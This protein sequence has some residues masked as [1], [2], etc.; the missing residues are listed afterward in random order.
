MG[1]NEPS[2]AQGA[3]RL[4]LPQWCSCFEPIKTQAPPELTAR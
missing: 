1:I 4:A 2:D 3:I